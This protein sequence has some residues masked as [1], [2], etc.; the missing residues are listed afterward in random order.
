MISGTAVC[1]RNICR[2]LSRGDTVKYTSDYMIDKD[3]R[4]YSVSF[5]AI[6]VKMPEMILTF[7]EKR[8]LMQEKSFKEIFH[9]VSKEINIPSL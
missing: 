9:V 2:E 3:E 6:E 8:L 5:E 4:F 7:T 1:R